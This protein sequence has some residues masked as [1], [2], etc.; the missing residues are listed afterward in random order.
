MRLELAENMQARGLINEGVPLAGWFSH[1]VKQVQSAASNV[2][3]AIKHTEQ[4]VVGAV[5]TIALAP[6][7]EMFLLMVSH[8]V[9]NTAGQLWDAINSHPDAVKRKWEQLGGSFSHLKSA[10]NAGSG[11]V[12]LSDGYNDYILNLR[13][14]GAQ[15]KPVDAGKIKEIIA[16][17]APILNAILP[18]IRQLFPKHQKDI[19]D[20]LKAA[21]DLNPGG[22]VDPTDPSHAGKFDFGGDASSFFASIPKPVLYIGAGLLVYSIIKK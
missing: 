10:V 11:K 13:D 5:K 2:G 22:S 17:A 1:F 6:A 4:Q 9:N 14:D 20:S 7:R 12:H 15:P 8:N 3:G 18:L 16:L 21:K 19:D